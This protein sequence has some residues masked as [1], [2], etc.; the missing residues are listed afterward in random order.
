MTLPRRRFLQAAGAGTAAA[1][2]LTALPKAALAATGLVP[3]STPEP[4]GQ[5]TTP[6]DGDWAFATDPGAAGTGAGW[7]Q[8]GFDD[9][10]WARLPVPG[11]WDLHDAYANYHGKAWYRRQFPSP[12]TSPGQVVRL[13]FEAVYYQAQVWFNGTLLGGHSGGYTPF[14]FDVTSLLAADGPNTVAVLADNTYSI[15]AWWA[16]GGISRS[17]NLTVNEA[18]RVE[19]QH[20]ITTPDLA[21]GTAALDVWI[22]VSN[23]S[24]TQVTVTVAGQ[25]TDTAGTPLT[26]VST[27]DAALTIGARGEAEAHLQ[28]H[29]PAGSFT[30]WQLDDPHLYLFATTVTD[31]AGALAHRRTDRFGIREVRIDGT[32][33]LL[34]GE[35]VRVNGYNRV[36]DDR[37]VGA[38]EPD[39]LVQRDIDRMKASGANMMRIH[40]VPQAP[41][42]LD[43]ADEKGLLLIEEI[44][45]WGKGANLDPN[46]PTTRGQFREMIRRDYNH[47]SIIAWSVCNEIAGTSDA[48]RTYVRTMIDWVR[49][50]LDS[51]RLLTYVSN[52]YS[53]ASTPAEEALQY[54]DF[55]CLNMY[56][57]FAGAADHAHQLF[58]DKPLFV[59]EFSSD[60]SSF[61]TSRE[62][63]DFRTTSD[64][65]AAAF[66]GRPWL[67]GASLWSYNDYR[68]GFS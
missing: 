41:N 27:V 9:S 58:P 15:G 22:T 11:N 47:P 46:D 16:W 38:T 13:R 48:G 45:V 3:E 10:D 60:S 67:I 4:T 68:S 43:Y 21:A 31:P 32:A 55:C 2:L 29:L 65:A 52:T 53:G 8:P 49:H 18:V 42:L 23:A 1:A 57:N 59:S 39:Y 37:V 40:H 35:Q 62:L 26:G 6:L 33:L 28:I 44:P 64:A 5:S 54:T 66:R 24:S 63:V 56:G 50:E 34:N 61:P 20:V 36:G 14:E 7:Q 30:L 17:V 19:R 51:T 12:A 25:V